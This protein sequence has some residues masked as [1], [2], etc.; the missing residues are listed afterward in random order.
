MRSCHRE[1]NAAPWKHD[2]SAGQV[3][4]AIVRDLIDL[5]ID[6]QLPCREGTGLNELSC[7]PACTGAAAFVY[8]TVPMRIFAKKLGSAPCSAMAR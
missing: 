8:G 6:V 2:S 5:A 1:P 3:N 4:T 7:R